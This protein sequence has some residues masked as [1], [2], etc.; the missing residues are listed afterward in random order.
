[1]QDFLS[2]VVVSVVGAVLLAFLSPRHKQRDVGLL[3][4]AFGAHVAAGAA[5][6]LLTLSLYGGGDIFGYARNG[7]ELAAACRADFQTVGWELVKVLFQ[8]PAAL[9]I[10]VPGLGS[11]TASMTAISAFISYF[12]GGGIY[13]GCVMLG[14]AAFFGKLA[15]YEVFR[16]SYPEPMHRRL[17]I[18]NMLVPSVVF[19]SS[20]LL[21]EAVA[22]VGLGPLMLGTHR[23]LN[24][25][26]LSGIL[27]VGFGAITVALV[28]P[29]ILFA[30][31]LAAGA[32]AYAHWAWA[33]Q[34][35]R[36]RPI[37]LAMGLMVATIALA[38]LG[39]LFPQYALETLA[40]QAAYH[41]EV[42]QRVRGGSTYELIG[43][44]ADT[45]FSVQLAY[46]PLALLTSLFRPLI[47]ES[48][49]AQILLN[50]LETTT[51][52]A[53]TLTL[54]KRA[55][56]RSLWAALLA[57]PLAIFCFMFVML[58][59]IAVGLTTTN[60]GTLSRYRMPLVPYF[61][62]L[63]VLLLT[64]EKRAPTP[65]AMQQSRAPFPPRGPAPGRGSGAA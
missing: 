36:L 25:R 54:L 39:K 3:A 34:I 55:T 30:F 14:V 2:A 10:N 61:T 7:E 1:M 20:G 64:A 35:P 12:T 46:A 8:Q 13:T 24:G 47:F 32:W 65:V 27:L 28:K 57:S 5:Q 48:S 6:V 21:K 58:L 37:Q 49:N 50:A 62:S 42:G 38:L 52:L 44:T 51:L 53:M 17:L 9:P 60:L 33:G 4:L 45:S 63:L 59:G 40:E 29:Y 11:S 16:L 18:A 41:Q 23:T 31:V 19:W 43:E 56:L 15:T 26:Q 22:M